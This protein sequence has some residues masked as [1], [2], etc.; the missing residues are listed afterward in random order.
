MRIVGKIIS[1][2]GVV[3]YREE[4][5]KLEP[6]LRNAYSRENDIPEIAQ[7]ILILAEDH[8]FFRHQGVDII[9][10]CRAIWRQATRGVLEGGSTIEQQLVRVITA[11]Y[12]RTFRRK[13]REIC[14]ATLVT[15]VIPKESV[16]S[17]YLAHAYF[18]WRMNGF[19]QAC[20]LLGVNPKCLSLNQA[21][22]VISRIKYPQS[23]SLSQHRAMLIRRRKNHLINKYFRNQNSSQKTVG[24]FVTP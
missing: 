5:R 21:A 7:Q 14:L 2:I 8:R 6:L 17:V 16:P 10:I 22:E 12:E 23:Q 9:S 4:W 3:M 19:T 1:L 15:R 20:S 18:G 13:F 11:R 24:F